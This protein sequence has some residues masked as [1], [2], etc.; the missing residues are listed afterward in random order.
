M[1]K[2]FSTS[3][4]ASRQVRKQRKY[5]ANAPIHIKRKLING[6]FDTGNP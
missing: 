3:W 4:K 6:T 2:E 1:K 5:L